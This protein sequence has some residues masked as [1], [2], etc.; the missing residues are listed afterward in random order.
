MLEQHA[1]FFSAWVKSEVVILDASQHETGSAETKPKSP[2]SQELADALS[3]VVTGARQH[4][5]LRN[6]DLLIDLLAYQLSHALRRSGPLGISTGE[7]P[8]WPS[9]EGG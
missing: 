4:A 8:N 5:A 7:V 6:P 1:I 9:T 2:I 3:R